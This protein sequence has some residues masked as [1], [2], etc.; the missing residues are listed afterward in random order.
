MVTG[1]RVM[2]MSRQE[3]SPPSNHVFTVKNFAGS[4]AF[5][6]NAHCGFVRTCS[7]HLDERVTSDVACRR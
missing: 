2:N 6:L 1:A 5:D 4:C 7:S 3:M